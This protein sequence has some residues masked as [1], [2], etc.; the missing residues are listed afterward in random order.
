MQREGRILRPRWWVNEF[1]QQFLRDQM[2]LDGEQVTEQSERVVRYLCVRTG[3]LVKRGD[4][5]FGFSHRTFQEYFA[6]RGLLLEVDGGGDIAAMLRP[7][8]YHPQWEEVVVYV[9]ASLTVQRATTLLRVILEDPDPAGRF[10]RRGQSLALRCLVDGAAVAN[11]ALLDQVFSDGTVVGGS[12]WLG[13]TLGFTRLL[14]QLLVTRHQAEAR[15]ML[16][17]IEGAAKTELSDSSYF[18]VY[19]SVHEPPNGPRDD[20]PGKVCRRN[21]GGR[22]VELFWPAW[23]KQRE[24]PDAWDSEV[25]KRIRDPKIDVTTR[26]TL[27]SL[28][29]KESVSKVKVQQTLYGLLGRD[30]RPEIRALMRR[31]LE[32]AASADSKIVKLLV[33]RLDKDSSD[34]VRSQCARA[35]RGLAPNQNEVRLRLEKLFAR[36]PALVRVG[37]ARGL[38]QLDLTSPDREALRARFLSTI[39]S[40]SARLGCA[41]PLSVSSLRSSEGKA[42]PKSTGGSNNPLMTSSRVCGPRRSMR[43]QMRSQRGE[44]SGRRHWSKD[45]R[46]CSWLFRTR[47]SIFSAI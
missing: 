25:L 2:G 30:P 28:L 32:E 36:G 34:V 37:A 11:R 45:S 5:V 33:D 31:A 17:E 9:A 46:R 29:G 42:W 40:P 21:V 35:L 6:A 18:V 41:A 27:I 22:F 14:K 20:T 38:S 19:S 39:A 7:F 1:V 4:G 15:R 23:G 24:D 12:R 3:L 47:A 16:G 13:I 44:G 26:V 10:L 8:L 43:W